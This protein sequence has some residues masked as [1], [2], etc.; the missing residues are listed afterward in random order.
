MVES[1]CRKS[2][3][4]F[5]KM[6]ALFIELLLRHPSTNGLVENAVVLRGVYC[7]P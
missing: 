2:L 3:K 1:L 4:I 5:A 7:E 6:T